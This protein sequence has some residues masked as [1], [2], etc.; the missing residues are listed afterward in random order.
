MRVFFAIGTGAAERAFIELVPQCIGCGRGSIG[1][2]GE[3]TFF[4]TRAHFA[5]DTEL[6]AELV[7]KRIGCGRGSVGRVGE[8]TFFALGIRA[9]ERASFA[10]GSDLV[11]K[12]IGF[13]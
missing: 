10:I 2:V 5:F 13:G 6:D 7:P 3:R 1:R 8:R 9:A 4:A 11:P 12:C